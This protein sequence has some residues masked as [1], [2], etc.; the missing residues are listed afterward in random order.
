MLFPKFSKILTALVL[1]LL[2]NP[3]AQMDKAAGIY[4]SHLTELLY[5]QGQ[6]FL[7]TFW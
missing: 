1:R 4:L 5:E 6:I 2:R 3:I 7:K